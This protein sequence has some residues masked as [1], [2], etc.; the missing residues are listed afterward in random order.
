M[1]NLL[2]SFFLVIFIVGCGV[3]QKDEPV[4]NLDEERKAVHQVI[5]DYHQGNTDENWFQVEKTLAE[6]VVFFGTDSAETIKSRAEFQTKLKEQAAKYKIKYLQIL[7]ETITMDD[8]ATVA[9][10]IYGVPIN[11]EFRGNV[12]HA[13]T[14][15]S[16]TLKKENGNWLITSG[17]VGV[18]ATSPDFVRFQQDMSGKPADTTAIQPDNA[19]GKEKE[20]KQK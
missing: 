14:R 1:K 20:K 16:K 18:A 9:S 5:A 2:L 19:K 6:N 13:F 8:K 17:I 4:V 7:D 11:I 12:Y 15:Q 10:I 3:K